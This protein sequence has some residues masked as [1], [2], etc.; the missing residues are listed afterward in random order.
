MRMHVLSFPIYRTKREK[1]L[2][3]TKHR[4][5]T[6]YALVPHVRHFFLMHR[7]GGE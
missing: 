4:K 6:V 1:L 7:G 3:Q 2:V 5:G